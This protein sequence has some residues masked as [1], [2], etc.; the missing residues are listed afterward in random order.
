MI[1]DVNSRSFHRI[2]VSIVGIFPFNLMCLS[3]III[4]FSLYL[5]YM[6]VS[7]P[8][9]EDIGSNSV[10][11]FAYTSLIFRRQDVYDSSVL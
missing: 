3:L 11:L 6:Q 4:S 9:F 7:F 10:F 2:F 1:R 8:H 5:Q